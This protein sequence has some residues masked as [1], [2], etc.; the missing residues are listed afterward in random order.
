MVMERPPHATKKRVQKTLLYPDGRQVCAYLGMVDDNGVFVYICDSGENVHL[1]YC[2]STAMIADAERE[3][4]LVE[5][6]LKAVR[7]LYDASEKYADSLAR[8][9]NRCVALLD[10]VFDVAKIPKSANELKEKKR[11]L[12]SDISRKVVLDD[13]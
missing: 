11:H 7:K 8:L 2:D 6:E 3:R 5:D 13:E 10:T 4:K 9:L 1:S 12:K